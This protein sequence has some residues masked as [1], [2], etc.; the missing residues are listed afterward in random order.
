MRYRLVRVFSLMRFGPHWF[1]Q[2]SSCSMLLGSKIICALVYLYRTFTFY[3]LTF[4]LILVRQYYILNILQFFIILSRYPL[5]ATAVSLTRIKVWA[6]PGSL[7]AT[8]GIVFTFFSSGY[9]DVS[10]HPVPSFVLRLHLSRLLHSEILG[11][12][13]RLQLT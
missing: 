7:A 11:S 4:Q 8:S 1:T 3:G 13:A 6:W 10:V 5:C 2:N 12:C 9:L